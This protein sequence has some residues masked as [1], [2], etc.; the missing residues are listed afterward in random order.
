MHGLHSVRQSLVHSFI[1]P[2][3][4]SLNLLCPG[5]MRG[6]QLCMGARATLAA[7]SPRACWGMT[8]R[9]SATLLAAHLWCVRFRQDAESFASGWGSR[10]PSA[11]AGSQAAMV[12]HAEARLVARLTPGQGRETEESV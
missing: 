11:E 12:A 2:P 8:G 7:G 1:H 9:S 4:Q 6:T 3:Q 5:P 10:L